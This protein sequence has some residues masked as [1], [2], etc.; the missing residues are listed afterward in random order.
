MPP[1]CMY[2]FT[3]MFVRMR[4]SMNLPDALL[5]DARARAAAEG[6]TVTNLVVEGLRARLAAPRASTRATINPPSRRLGRPRVD[7]SDNQAVRTILDAETDRPFGD[8]R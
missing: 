4:T 2:A 5:E 1:I 3:G 7:I 6:S 8:S